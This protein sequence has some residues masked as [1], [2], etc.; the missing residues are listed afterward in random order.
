MAS[1]PML[2]DDLVSDKMTQLI[3]T[4][5]RLDAA[6]QF[7]GVK[8]KGS[9]CPTWVYEAIPNPVNPPNLYRAMLDKRLG[10]RKT[11]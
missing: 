11:G 8:L 4:P 7:V 10:A 9:F 2:L 1:L 3:P 6:V 5:S